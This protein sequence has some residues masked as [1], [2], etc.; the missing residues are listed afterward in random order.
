MMV[1]M[2]K[3]RKREVMQPMIVL[4]CSNSLPTY[5]DSTDVHLNAKCWFVMMYDV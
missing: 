4:G 2:S 5:L 3:E 1:T